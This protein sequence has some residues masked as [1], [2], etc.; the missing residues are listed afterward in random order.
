MVEDKVPV[1]KDELVAPLT[2]ANVMLSEEL[3]HWMLPVAYPVDGVAL[4]VAEPELQ[5]LVP[6]EL[7]VADAG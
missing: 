1:A 3:C 2:S 6:V 4:K 5:K 7:K